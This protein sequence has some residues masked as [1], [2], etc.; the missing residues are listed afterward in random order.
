M[1]WISKIRNDLAFHYPTYDKSKK[2]LTESNFANFSVYGDMNAGNTW[3]YGAEQIV[4]LILF[5]RAIDPNDHA[6]SIDQ[7]EEMISEIISYLHEL[8]KLLDE[9]LACYAG[10]I[11]KNGF[12]VSEPRSFDAPH[13]S[14]FTLPVYLDLSKIKQP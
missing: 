6:K 11:F 10:S 14:D 9:L 13:Y 5:D 7:A 12:E 3:H 1:R 8:N 4:Q 2:H